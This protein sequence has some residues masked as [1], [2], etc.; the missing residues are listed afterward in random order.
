[1]K[2]YLYH[3]RN[4]VSKINNNGFVKRQI[5]SL[6]VE[7]LNLLEIKEE[8]VSID[9]V[10][11]SNDIDVFLILSFGVSMNPETLA[12]RM[13]EIKISIG[14]I[15]QKD[16]GKQIDLKIKTKM[17]PKYN[18]VVQSSKKEKEE[19][20]NESGGEVSELDYEQRSKMFVP[21]DP[22]Y[23]FDRVILPE[24]VKEKIEH[25]LNILK[26]EKKVFDDWGLYE[27]QPR[28]SSSLSFCATA[29]AAMVFPVP[30]GP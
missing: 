19:M 18:G 29:S 3:S 1:M 6:L 8:D 22:A 24:E 25:A 28:P 11:I 27:I 23:S 16:Q 21:V 2:A 10:S 13:D 30:D 15:I 26:Y 7:K 5:A 17:D 20:N 12:K 14:Q 9:C 4:K